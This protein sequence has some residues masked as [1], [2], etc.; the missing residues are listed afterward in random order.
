MESLYGLWGDQAASIEGARRRST[1]QIISQHSE[2]G[3]QYRDVCFHLGDVPGGVRLVLRSA[4]SQQCCERD[5]S[6]LNILRLHIA[7]C[8]F[9][10]ATL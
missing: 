4:F 10:P 6:V 9:W 5:R 1:F 3:D 7:F 8:L 2:N